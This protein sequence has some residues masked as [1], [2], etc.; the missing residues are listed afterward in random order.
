MKNFINKIV[1]LYVANKKFHS[2]VVALEFA[3]V[4][5]VTTY[6]GG[7]PTSH[8]AWAAFVSGLLGAVWGGLKGWLRNNAV[9][10]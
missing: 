2:F 7:L 4:G 10:Q 1:A 9:Q 3:A 8:D 5:F 6:Q